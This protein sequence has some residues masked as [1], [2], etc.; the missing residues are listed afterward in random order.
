MILVEENRKNL[1]EFEYTTM[2][3]KN[4]LNTCKDKLKE[5]TEKISLFGFQSKER[6]CNYL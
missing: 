2:N 1:D 5:R 4:S 6:I 3:I